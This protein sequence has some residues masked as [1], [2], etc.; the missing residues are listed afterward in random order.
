MKDDTVKDVGLVVVTEDGEG[1]EKEECEQVTATVSNRLALMVGQF[2]ADL[3]GAPPGD[4]G[5]TE[6]DGVFNGGGPFELRR[7]KE[8]ATA[9]ARLEIDSKGSGGS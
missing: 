3:I 7:F 9:S 1:K 2:Q 8:E 6:A 5:S 4:N